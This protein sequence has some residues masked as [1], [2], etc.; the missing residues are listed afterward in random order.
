MSNSISASMGFLNQIKSGSTRGI[1]II[2]AVVF[3]IISG[4]F[5][6][7]FNYSLQQKS[8]L[9]VEQSNL[10]EEAFMLN[11]NLENE[12]QN[13]LKSSL[14]FNV[15]NKE[16]DRFQTIYSIKST[17]EIFDKYKEVNSGIDDSEFVIE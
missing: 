13:S 8:D 6:L 2:F 5:F 12:V 16:I 3:I 14:L 11:R 7:L 15:S 4:V 10:R 17:K 9:L 1:F